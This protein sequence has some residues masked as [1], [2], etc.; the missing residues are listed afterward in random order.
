MR[1][2]LY[3]NVR[4]LP[5]K[6]EREAYTVGGCLSVAIRLLRVCYAVVRLFCVIHEALPIM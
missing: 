1:H 6:V 2:Y 5:E 3:C 4:A